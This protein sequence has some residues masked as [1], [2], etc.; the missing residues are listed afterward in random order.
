MLLVSFLTERK[1]C[2]HSGFTE[3]SPSLR[4]F[5]STKGLSASANAA[6]PF[7]HKHVAAKPFAANHT[8]TAALSA[9]QSSP[10]ATSS[11]PFCN[12][13]AALLHA[14]RSP[15]ATR[16]HSGV[17]AKEK[18]TWNPISSLPVSKADHA[19]YNDSHCLTHRALTASLGMRQSPRGLRLTLLTLGPSGRQ[20]R[21]N[22]WLKKRR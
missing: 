20:E 12:L 11:Q 17:N 2:F 1:P 10:F 7:S 3:T 22:C 4:A 13:I 21:L 18:R 5:S 6:S 9:A 14:N 19:V 16:K 15:F 8:P